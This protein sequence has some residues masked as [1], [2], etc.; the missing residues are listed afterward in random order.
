[1]VHQDLRQEIGGFRT[2]LIIALLVVIVGTVVIYDSGSCCYCLHSCS[3]VVKSNRVAVGIANPLCLQQIL[4][5]FAC[6]NPCFN[7]LNPQY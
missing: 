7:W 5:V 4:L 1:M 6:R 2:A 3:N